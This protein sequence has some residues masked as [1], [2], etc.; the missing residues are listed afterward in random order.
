[1]NLEETI[2]DMVKGFIEQ[3]GI[4]CVEEVYQVDSVNE[5]CVDF[6]AELVETMLG[7][8]L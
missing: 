2:C 3:N 4:E 8:A 1:M 7:S 5:S 6:V